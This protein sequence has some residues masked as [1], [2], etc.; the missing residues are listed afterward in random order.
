MGNRLDAALHSFHCLFA[1]K[2]LMKAKA[3]AATCK[4]R[5]RRER[6]GRAKKSVF[7]DEQRKLYLL[8]LA[9]NGSQ[10]ILR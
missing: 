3:I 7:I 10:H 9:R 8:P 5:M 2:A 4:N 1:T 6:E